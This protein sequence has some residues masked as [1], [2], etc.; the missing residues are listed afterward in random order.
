MTPTNATQASLGIISQDLPPCIFK[1]PPSGGRM[2]GVRV[3]RAGRRARDRSSTG[4]QTPWRTRIPPR[5]FSEQ[6]HGPL[7]SGKSASA[8]KGKAV[9]DDPRPVVGI[10]I[11]KDRPDVACLPAAVRCPRPPRRHQQPRPL[12]LQ[13]YHKFPN[14]SSAP[15]GLIRQRTTLQASCTFRMARSATSSPR[16]P[17]ASRPSASSASSEVRSGSD[18]FCTPGGLASGLST[19]CP[20]GSSSKP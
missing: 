4:W 12:P 11:S 2:Q 14:R 9:M 18:R 5:L 17:A 10:D 7:P 13:A 20:R 1:H 8:R 16:S 15:G 19:G 3:S 6:S